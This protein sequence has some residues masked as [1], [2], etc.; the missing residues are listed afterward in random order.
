MIALAQAIN[1]LFQILTILILARVVLSF[2]RIDPYHPT[3]GPIMRF[4]YDVTEPIMA[5][6]RRIMPPMG[7]FDFSPVIVL[8][9]ADLVRRLIVGTLIGL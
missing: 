4:V 2:L 1:W 8:L 6:V 3:W 7:G 9:L 5:P